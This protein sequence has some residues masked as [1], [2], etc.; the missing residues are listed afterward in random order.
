MADSENSKA[1]YSDM[2]REIE[3]ARLSSVEFVLND[4]LQLRFDGPTLTVIN[5]PY[6]R[7]PTGTVR[8]G[9][10]GFRDAVCELITHEVASTEVRVD[11][12]VEL[13]FDNGATFI[14]PLGYDDYRCPEAL[15]FDGSSSWW[16]L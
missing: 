8:W 13:H 7:T 4:Y 1:G 14:V 6:I 12:A 5:N 16:V 3:G 10:A 15:T 2:L 11:D 9:E